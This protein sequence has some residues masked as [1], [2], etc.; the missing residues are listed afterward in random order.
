MFN[1]PKASIFTHGMYSEPFETQIGVKQ[2]DAY[3]VHYF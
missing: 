2:G 1:S 3:L